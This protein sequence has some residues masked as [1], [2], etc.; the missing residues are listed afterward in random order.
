MLDSNP[1]VTPRVM[2]VK[3]AAIVRAT[4]KFSTKKYGTKR[5]QRLIIIALRTIQSPMSIPGDGGS[6]VK[7][8]IS[9]MKTFTGA[10]IN[11]TARIDG[12]LVNRKLLWKMKRSTKIP[13]TITTHFMR[14][15]PDVCDEKK[16]I[17]QLIV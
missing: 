15:Y 9:L 7:S 11:T 1:K 6:C 13:T 5:E 3:S 12:I 2:P 4:M 17:F 14:R 10:M 8:A 16:S